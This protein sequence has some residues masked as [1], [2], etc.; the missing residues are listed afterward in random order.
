MQRVSAS[1]V[2]SGVVLMDLILGVIILAVVG[3]VK[4]GQKVHEMIVESRGRKRERDQA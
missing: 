4:V 1:L 2:V 3:L